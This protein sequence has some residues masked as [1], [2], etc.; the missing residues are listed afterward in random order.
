MRSPLHNEPLKQGYGKVVEETGATTPPPTPK[1][2]FQGQKTIGE[3]GP[4]SKTPT[5]DKFMQTN[6]RPSVSS[7][8]PSYLDKVTEKAKMVQ[9]FLG[10]AGSILTGIKNIQDIPANIISAGA[11]P[12]TPKSMITGP[13]EKEMQEQKRREEKKAESDEARKELPA[14]GSFSKSVSPMPIAKSNINQGNKPQSSF[15]GK[16][17]EVKNTFKI[18]E[19]D[20]NV[21]VK[22]NITDSNTGAETDMDGDRLDAADKAIEKIDEKEGSGNELYDYNPRMYA[23]RKARQDRRLSRQLEGE[24]RRVRKEYGNEQG[25]LVRAQNDPKIKELR[26]YKSPGAVAMTG[27][28][29]GRPANANLLMTAP[30]ITTDK[31]SM[32]DAVAKLKMKNIAQSE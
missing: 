30:V 10:G 11:K 5:I 18:E 27:D 8:E 12:P 2:S 20:G 22:D 25:D 24:E 15:K 21:E 23:R 31:H 6:Q 17:S 19:E 9:N 29:A 7:N 26:T 1:K 3:S 13:S 32:K 28:R 14:R 4:R 16:A